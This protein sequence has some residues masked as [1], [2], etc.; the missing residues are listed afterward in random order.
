MNTKDAGKREQ[1]KWSLEE[2][3]LFG[4]FQFVCCSDCELSTPFANQ[5]YTV[6][7]TL[8]WW[9]SCYAILNFVFSIGRRGPLHRIHIFTGNWNWMYDVRIPEILD[10]QHF[11]HCPAIEYVK[12]SNADRHECRGIDE[13]LWNHHLPLE[14]QYF[15]KKRGKC[16]ME[17]DNSKSTLVGIK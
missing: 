13:C 5:H 14:I 15:S 16:T 17:Y 4:Y 2:L 3:S 12:Y 7:W 1:K 9:W 11:V 8:W 6:Q 10:L